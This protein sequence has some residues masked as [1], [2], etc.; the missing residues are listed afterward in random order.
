MQPRIA[1]RVTKVSFNLNDHR[2]DPAVRTWDLPP[3]GH[4]MSKCVLPLFLRIGRTLQPIGSAYW[5]AGKTP[6]VMTALHCVTETLRHEERYARRF[7]AGDLPEKIDLSETALYVLH[8]DDCEGERRRFTL[9]PLESVNAG[10]PGDVVF[11]FPQF[12]AGRATWAPP[13]TFNPPRIGSTVFSVGYTEMKVDGGI[14][15]DEVQAGTFDWGRYS[16]RLIVT[17]GVVETVFTRQFAAGFG[18]GPCFAFDNAI[19]HGQ[20]GG[21]IFST[22]NRIV[23]LNSSTATHF[24]GRPVSLGAMFYPLL[25]TP[26]KFGLT[27]GGPGAFIRLNAAYRLIDMIAQGAVKT[28]G[29]E[30]RVGLSPLDDGGFAIGPQIPR[31]DHH[32][33]HADFMSMQENRPKEFATN[34]YRFVPPRE[35]G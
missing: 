19:D 13:L 20:S 16:H 30:T 1:Q 7:A 26:L 31:D 23:G 21:P 11:G 9:L 2:P 35:L 8:Q 28:D 33:V 15:L 27:L 22:D 12:Q 24:F 34:I 14:E 6:F 25:L 10:P 17:E 4:V 29:S 3:W 32:S 18:G 5:V